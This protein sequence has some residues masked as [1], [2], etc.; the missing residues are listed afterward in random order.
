MKTRALLAAVLVVGVVVPASEASAALKGTSGAVTQ[1]S[2]PAAVSTLK[3]NS[4]TFAW[5]EQQGVTLASALKVD[6]TTPGNYVGPSVTLSPGTIP[7][8]TV[9][10]S[11]FFHSLR[12]SG[13][14][15]LTGTMTF[16]T[17]VLGV[18]VTHQKLTDSNVLG[19]TGTDYTANVNNGLEFGTGDAVFMPDQ[20]TVTVQANTA[21][22]GDEVRIITAAD[23]PPTANAGGPY[24][25]FEGSPLTLNGTDTN[26]D[27]N[28]LTISWSFATTGKPGTVC[29]P[30]GTTTLTPTITCNDAAMVTATLSVQDPYHAAVVSTAN[31]TIANVSPVLGALTAPAGPVA[32]GTTVNVSAAFTDAGT[33]DSHI[34]SVTWGDTTK[35]PLA[36]ISEANGSGTLSA[37]HSYTL[38]GLYTITVTLSDTEGA[39][40]VRTTQVLVNSPPTANAGGPYSTTEGTPAGLTGTAS[41]PD[42]DPL[43]TQWTFTP[44]PAHPGTTC[45]STATSTLTPTIGC[46]DVAVV[47]AQLSASDNVNPP[48]VSNTTVTVN[49]VPPVL[50]PLTAPNIVAIGAPADLSAAFTDAGTHDTHTATVDWGD[51]SQTNAN[52][53]EANGS[54]SL[55]ASHAYAQPGLYTVTVTLTDDNG[56]TD[57]RTTTILVNS[58]PVVDAG[59][60]YVGVEGTP[61][62]LAG[63]ASDVDGDTL[64]Y[65]WSFSWTGAHP[66]TV[67]TATG[68]GVHAL[69]LSLVC[70]DVAVVTATLTADDGVNPPV[71]S[72]P[73]TLTVGN[74]APTVD[75]VVQSATAPAGTTAAISATFSDAGTNDTHTATIDW[76][77]GHTTPGTVSE[78]GGNGTVTGSHLY[79]TDGSYTVTVTVNDDNNGSGSST[80]TVIS[81]TTPPVITATVSPPPNAAGWNDSPTTVTWSVTDSLSPIDSMAGCDPTTLSTDTAGTAFTCTAVSRG[82]SATQSVTVKLDQVAPV[83]T[84]APT[85]AANANGWY[86]APVTIHWTCSDALSG[87][88]GSCPAAS[89]LS[90]EGTG[91]SANASVS[92]VASNATNASSVPVQIDLTAPVTTASAVPTWSN[93]DVVLTL[94]ATDSLSGVAVTNYIV[95]GGPV[96]SGTSVVLTT[97]G[98][99]T[100]AYWS[101]DAAGNV[102]AAKTSTVRIDKTAPTI[103]SSQDPPANSAG[104]NN[105]NVTVSFNCTDSLS[106]I[107]TCS[108]PQ[109]VTTEGSGQTVTGTATDNAGNS[110]STTASLNIDKTPPTITGSVPP[111]NVN[112][113]YNAPVTVTFTCADSL[114]GIASCPSPTTVSADGAGQSVSGVA[115][116]TAGNTSFTSVNGINVDQT[117]PTITATASPAPNTSG[118]NNGPVTVS[119][120]CSD[121][122][123]GNAEGACPADQTVSTDGISTVAGTVTDRAGNSSSTS[124]VVRIDTVPPAITGAQ[125]PP[126]NS[127]GWNN[128]AVTVSF[129]CTDSGSGIATAGCSAPTTL[130]EGAN[131][132]VTGTAVDSA[133]NTATTTVSGVNIDETPPTLSGVPTTAPNAN[134][135][136]NGP[137]VIHW[138]CADALSGIAGSCPADSV[139]N[140]EGTGETTSA[141]VSDVAGNTTTAVSPPVNIDETAPTTS[142][143][144]I[145]AWSNGAVTLTLTATDNLSGVAST[146]YSVDGGSTQTGTSIV[147]TTTGVHTVQFWSTDR[148]GNVEA[149]NTAIV[150]I[151]LTAPTITAT[152]SPAANGAGWNNTDVTVTF[153]CTDTISGIASCTSPQKVTTEG[154]GQIVTGQA[155]NNAGTTASVTTTLNIDKT[156]PTIVASVP[157]ANANGWYNTPVTVGWSCA[158][159]LSG[160]ASCPTPTTLSSDGA[161]Q[162]TTGTASDTAGN[163]ATAT[164]S[165]INIDQIPPTLTASVPA[166]S[167]GWYSG[168]VTIKWTCGDSLSGVSSCP[169]DQTITA[170]GVTT[171][172]QTISDNAGNLTTDSVTVR[173][174]KTPPTIVGSASPAPNGNG[175]NNTNVTVSFACTDTLSGVGTC[176]A[177]VTLGEGAGQSAKG[178]ATDVAGNTASA[179]VSN[180]NV[181]KTP[182]TLSGAPT[183]SPNASGWYNHAV[184]IHWTCADALSGVD[185][186]TCPTDSVISVEGAAQQLSR[187]VSDLA[188]NTTTATSPAVNIDLT[189]PVTSATTTVHPTNVTVQLTATDNLSGVAKTEYSVDG[190]ATQVG[191]SVTISGTGSHTL[192]YFSVDNAGN[193][194]GTHVAT[195]TIAPTAPPKITSSQAPPPNGAGWNNSNVTVTFTCSDP[196]GITSCT[197]PQTVT[198]QG[199]GQKVVGTATNT[200]GIT[201]STTATVSID[202]T[203]PTI[204][205]SLSR[206]AN[207][208]G[209]YSAPVSASFVCTDSLSGVG[210]CP[211][212]VTF[213]QGANQTATATA[214]DVAGNSASTI[215]GPVNVDLTK[216]T[217][218]AT[219]SGMLSNGVY[220]GPVTIHFTCTD[221]LSGIVPVTGCPPDQVVSNSG[222]TTVTGTATDR[223]GNT[224]TTSIT[225]TVKQVCQEEEGTLI[226]IGNWQNRS[227]YDDAQKLKGVEGEIGRFDDPSNCERDGDHLDHNH[228]DECFG[229]QHDAIDGLEGLIGIHSVPASVINGWISD[230]TNSSRDIAQTALN[231]ATAQRG[232][233]YWI[234]KGQSAV[235]A[236][237]QSSAHGD[238]ATAVTDYENAWNDA[239]QA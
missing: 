117:P 186:A 103:T 3:S 40:S 214:T 128:T 188:G 226:D 51:L 147:I 45:T 76:G 142:V 177:P 236:G 222:T 149:A 213:G 211:T 199:A 22:D 158:D 85:A 172:A 32:P 202:K 217:I 221:A 153:T 109:T 112:G 44:T 239:Q 91:V 49:N 159:T 238:D 30:T 164:A 111:A 62:S 137:V 43:T 126:A 176:S 68:A 207:S 168:P 6:I 206:A 133:G 122:T 88:S 100:V 127:A 38:S 145:P 5:N 64:A 9:V 101:T 67:C 79:A 98:I 31:V 183:G 55:T 15:T 36:N 4:T 180:I 194:E 165:G 119:F 74:A 1:I 13:T 223:A 39:P 198:T 58:S 77:D 20:R 21:N 95:D 53:T 135:W 175:W 132:N 124:V 125:T 52:I 90:T 99:H 192:T 69:T 93:N 78:S 201:A 225:V 115:T 220:S 218:T 70:N 18:E 148:A 173:I 108:N 140:S 151:D 131:Q 150:K 203:P 34:A 208:Y 11:Q 134:G 107:A 196:T 2:P 118:W 227:S 215:V 59:G 169:S 97:E 189:A 152:P 27:N 144:P 136:Y 50:A 167:T 116:D 24:S 195:I 156:P 141:A 209:W 41:D 143:S 233:P 205:G 155:V 8:G 86:N 35:T 229:N 170:E 94:S 129:T 163:T 178:T 75:T 130:G 187:S 46:D 89:T 61:M 190:G 197:P 185:P 200:G 146:S 73:T 26:P 224:A 60:P 114:S 160:V 179:T 191:T 231:D 65:T 154:A 71:T 210:T 42:G 234:S 54:G 212:P 25:G 139:S 14:S 237:D 29:T 161:G 120:T 10:D 193:V 232:N 33:N 138:T 16:P 84:G 123:S 12:V 96:Q 48:V 17:D 19:A 80:G 174:D 219:A 230:L 113:W 166:T 81:D 110:A 83:L 162:S 66:G 23:R 56:G 37:S 171:V 92:D 47:N 104:W 7:A 105:S 102:E 182:P 204:V 121:A 63:T 184:T 28:P 181:D 228:G 106:G 216:P 82:G 235:S 72:A 87:V 157:P 57:A